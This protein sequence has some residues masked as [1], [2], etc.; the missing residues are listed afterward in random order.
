MEK[1]KIASRFITTAICEFGQ[2]EETR[3]AAVQA[4]LDF[5]GFKAKATCWPVFGG[6]WPKPC[7]GENGEEATKWLK[8][9]T[10]T[11]KRGKFETECEH[12]MSF[13]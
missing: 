10:D 4:L 1:E 3:I 13:L 8:E 12:V 9:I 6:I 2:S 11:M 5:K 7:E